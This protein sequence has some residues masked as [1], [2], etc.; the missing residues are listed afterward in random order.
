MR[1]IWLFFT[2]SLLISTTCVADETFLGFGVGVFD[3]AK[4]SPAEVR[5][6]SGGIRQE[7]YRGVYY[8]A[9]AG[10]W[11]D[12]SGD[13]KRTGSGFGSLGI[14]MLVDLHP[15]EIRSGWSLVGITSP[16]SYLGGPFQFMG[17]LY[18]GVRDSHE[19]GIGVGYGH[20]S[21]CGI[22]TPNIGRDTISIQLSQKW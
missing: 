8:Q 15:V 20:I 21:S 13:P 22:Y 3:S 16:D 2:L 18:L 14:G 5:M 12:S 9:Q 17:E 4:H 7:V 6:L 10:L 19:N 11:A 1:K